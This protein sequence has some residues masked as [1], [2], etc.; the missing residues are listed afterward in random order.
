MQL[1][2]NIS[3]QKTYFGLKILLSDFEDYQEKTDIFN[4][5]KTSFLEKW[6]SLKPHYH[7][8]PENRF[9]KNTVEF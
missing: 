2:E 9:F 8:L 7:F 6:I 4:V 3:Y 1:L 5:K